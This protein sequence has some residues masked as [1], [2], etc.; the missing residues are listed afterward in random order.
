MIDDIRALQLQVES[1]GLALVNSFTDKVV[2]SRTQRKEA[3]ARRTLD[4]YSSQLKQ[5][6]ESARDAFLDLANVLLFKYADGDIKQW[7]KAGFTSQAAGTLC[8]L[9]YYLLFRVLLRRSIDSL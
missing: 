1:A 5:N 4:D 6:I 3:L 7:T 8:V 2:A 9:L